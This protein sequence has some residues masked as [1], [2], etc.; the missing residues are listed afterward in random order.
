M[1]NQPIRTAPWSEVIGVLHSLSDDDSYVYVRIANTLLS[2]HK[3]SE[4]S[5]AILKNLSKDMLGKKIGV[6]FTD[7]PNEPIIVRTITHNQSKVVSSKCQSGE[8]KQAQSSNLAN[9]LRGGNC[10]ESK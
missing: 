8:G 2:F 5:G 4:E 7:L 6:L 3:E 1:D 10:S 9:L